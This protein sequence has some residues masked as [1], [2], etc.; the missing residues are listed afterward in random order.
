MSTKKIGVVGA[1]QMGG[2]IAQVAADKGHAVVLLDVSQAVAERGKG[3][4]AASLDKLVQKVENV[5]LGKPRSRKDWHDVARALKELL[6]RWDHVPAAIELLVCSGRVGE[7][8]TGE[9]A[10]ANARLQGSTSSSPAT[11][12]T[13]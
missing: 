11:T 4:I 8:A 12:S 3:K 1:G 13:S 7:T 9:K 2:G 6:P 5:Q 10:V